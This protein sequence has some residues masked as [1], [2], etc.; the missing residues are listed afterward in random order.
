M[1]ESND[2]PLLQFFVYEHLKAELRE[3]SKP[4][5]I[6]ARHLVSIL[7][8]N[9]ERSVALRKV[10]EAKGLR[11]AREALSR[12]TSKAGVGPRALLPGCPPRRPA[13]GFF[14]FSLSPVRKT[15]PFLSLLG[16]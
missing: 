16:V 6:L 15:H 14:A 11:R 2:E 7:P 9:P 8:R 12:M 3:V 4:F 13:A 5:G 10:L 1:T